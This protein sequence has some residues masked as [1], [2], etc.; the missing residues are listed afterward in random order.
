MSFTNF[1]ALQ[2]LTSVGG[3]DQFLVSLNNGLSGAAGF[4]RVT[5]AA[6]EKSLGVYTTVQTN[7]ATWG[8][9]GSS[10]GLTIFRQVSSITAPNSTVP[11]HALSALSLSANVDFA[12]IPNGTGALLAQISDGSAIGGDKRG[13]YATDWQRVRVN[14]SQVASGD[15]STIGGGSS[16][17][18]P[19]LYST[20]GGGDSNTASG[21]YATVVGGQ[22]NTASIDYATIGGGSSNTASG[23]YTIVG[24]GVLNTA[25]GE[26]SII[27]GG[28]GNIASGENSTIA[29]GDSNITSGPNSTVGGGQ[30]NVASGSFSTI[31]GGVDNAA[32]GSDSFIAGGVSNNTNSQA[33]TFILGSNITASLSNYTYV[34]N[35]SSQGD[36][37]ASS[38][39]GTIS[40]ATFVTSV[41]SI[42]VANYRLTLSNANKTTID[43]FS[44]NSY[45]GVPS[46]NT[47]AFPTGSQLTVVQGNKSA[48]NYT[49]LSAGAGVTI[50]SFN[51]SL[52]LAG[53]YA[54][55]TLIKTD[56][57]VWYLIG[58]LK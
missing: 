39:I 54:A 7:S 23:E 34:N 4:G 8:T 12:I 57:N 6:T 47:V 35:L 22:N 27:G 16:N 32:S 41:T 28:I 20:I 58:N 18:A 3:T 38:I 37:R 29:G 30:S 40:A 11:V 21:E 45:Y 43:T 51:N 1:A 49:V 17:I 46:N 48:S 26:Y 50:N 52:S 42:S 25:S 56:T 5:T 31:G 14:A 55:G 13:I 9:G 44:T 33:N 10:G 15:Y 36:I 24:G 2:S 19:N 53:N